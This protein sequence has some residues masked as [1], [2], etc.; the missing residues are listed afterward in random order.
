MSIDIKT[1]TIIDVIRQAPLLLGVGRNG[2]PPHKSFLIRAIR[3]G[4]NGHRLV[5]QR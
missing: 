1:E 5:L 2:K 4:I 3:K